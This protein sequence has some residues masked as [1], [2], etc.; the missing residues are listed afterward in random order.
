M[1]KSRQSMRGVKSGG[2]I[3]QKSNADT[4]QLMNKINAAGNVQQL[5]E[6]IGSHTETIA[7][8]LETLRLRLRQSDPSA[9]AD[10]ER[11]NKA[12]EAAMRGDSSGIVSSLCGVG[13]WVIS[14]AR[15]A[16]TSIIADMIEKQLGL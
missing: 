11:L 6:L 16:G 9:T 1:A 4:V 12:H 7:A 5:I 13:K 14:F 2:S 15:E 10:L 8:E 3:I